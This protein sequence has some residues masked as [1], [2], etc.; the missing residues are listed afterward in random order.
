[1][2]DG[3]AADWAAS[4]LIVS[5]IASKPGPWRA[6]ASV[7]PPIMPTGVSAADTSAQRGRLAERAGSI[8][9]VGDIEE[10]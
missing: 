2:I 7:Q 1:M 8:E 3:A 6:A 5:R 10:G 9:R 4:A